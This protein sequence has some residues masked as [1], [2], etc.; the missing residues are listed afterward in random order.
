MFKCLGVDLSL[1]KIEVYAEVLPLSY[2]ANPSKASPFPRNGK[3]LDYLT[4]HAG[5]PI[6]S[7]FAKGRG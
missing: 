2:L 7:S 5:H 4:E 3:I 1:P 6:K